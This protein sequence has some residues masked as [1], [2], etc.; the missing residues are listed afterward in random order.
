M[1]WAPNMAA[2]P[3]ASTSLTVNVPLSVV[4]PSRPR[5]VTIEDAAFVMSIFET[6]E[7]VIVLAPVGY[8]VL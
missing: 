6:I 3:D 5:I 1:P 7:T 2:A 8:G 4:E